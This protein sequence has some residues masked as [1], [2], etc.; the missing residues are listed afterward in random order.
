MRYSLVL[1]FFIVSFETTGC[2]QKINERDIP[3]PVKTAFNIKF[4]GATAVK[5]G[6]ENAKEYEAEFTFNSNAVS[7]NFGMDGS[8]VETESVIPTSQLPAPVIGAVD[9]KYPGA[10]ITLAEK[11]EQPG[12]KTL[13]EISVKVNGKKKSMELNPDGSTAH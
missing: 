1:A 10:S 6:K 11:T 13:Y 7:A 5:W 2:S 4:P 3:G 8:W 12:E 9:A